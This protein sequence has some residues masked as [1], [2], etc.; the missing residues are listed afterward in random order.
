MSNPVVHQVFNRDCVVYTTT[1]K[2]CSVLS[3]TCLI[4]SIVGF[5]LLVS[6][7]EMWKIWT[8]TITAVFAL[9]FAGVSIGLLY[10]CSDAKK[11]ILAVLDGTEAWHEYANELRVGKDRVS[12]P[13]PQL[14][15]IAA[16]YDAAVLLS[17]AARRRRR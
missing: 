7:P 17:L 10:R 16:Q 5:C 9:I 13:E 14:K 2:V 15:M 1:L 12:V 4:G 11:K 8:G 6:G 3:I